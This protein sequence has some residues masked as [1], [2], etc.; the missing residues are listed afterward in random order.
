[1]Q[2]EE[3]GYIGPRFEEYLQQARDVFLGPVFY[4]SHPKQQIYF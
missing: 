1:M 2:Y 3:S 4:D